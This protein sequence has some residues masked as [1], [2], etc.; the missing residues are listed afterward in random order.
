M[1]KYY[2]CGICGCVHRWEFT[3]DCR[4]D[5]ER[6]FCDELDAI[7]GPLGYELVSMEDRVAADNI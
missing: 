7:H 4:E 2:E 1:P 3:G 5:R 6:F